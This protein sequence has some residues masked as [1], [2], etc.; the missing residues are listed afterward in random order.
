MPETT[1]LPLTATAFQQLYWQCFCVLSAI[2]NI[3]R[4]VLTSLCLCGW[5]HVGVFII[6][7]SISS[8]KMYLLDSLYKQQKLLNT[9]ELHAEY[10]TGCVPVRN[11]ESQVW[12]MCNLANVRIMLQSISLVKAHFGSSTILSHEMCLAWKRPVWVWKQERMFVKHLKE[13]LSNYIGA[14]VY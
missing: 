4:W 12:G 3:F 9:D 2:Q 10:R 1:N 14:V 7:L 5:M 8:S 13:S 6:T 11:E